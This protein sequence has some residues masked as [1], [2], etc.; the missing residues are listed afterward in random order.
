MI[1]AA[2]SHTPAYSSTS[3]QTIH[4]SLALLPSLREKFPKLREE[5]HKYVKSLQTK[6]KDKLQI[7]TDGSVR[8]N[9]IKAA[10]SGAVIT[11]NNHTSE[12]CL[13]LATN[14]IAVAELKAVTSS[15]DLVRRN[16]IA[17]DKDITVFCDNKY[18]VGIANEVK[19]VNIS[20][21]ADAI[22]LHQLLFKMKQHRKIEII[23]IPAHCGIKLH[24]RADELAVKAAEQ[25]IALLAQAKAT[26]PSPGYSRPKVAVSARAP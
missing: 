8:G 12:L 10:G 7:Y 25:Q 22:N 15:L 11:H 13:S 4:R 23:W 18:V 9:P 6:H 3:N 21:I 19:K 14:S 2:L 26:G 5:A 1:T 16:N 24:D 17:P 20:H